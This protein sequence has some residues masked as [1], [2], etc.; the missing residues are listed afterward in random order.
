MQ[1]F[2]KIF[3]SQAFSVNAT[4]LPCE[5]TPTDGGEG[6]PKFSWSATAELINSQW[7]FYHSKHC[8]H[9]E[10]LR[11]EQDKGHRHL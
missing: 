3:L 5:T 1:N 11:G 8:S 2:D 6:G 10:F 9:A 4:Q 7:K